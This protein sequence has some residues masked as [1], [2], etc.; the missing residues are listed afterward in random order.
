MEATR[1]MAIVA[2]WRSVPAGSGSAP[3]A[4]IRSTYRS[5]MV[6]ALLPDHANENLDE[7]RLQNDL[8]SSASRPVLLVPNGWRE[9]PNGQHITI[10]WEPC[11]RRRASLPFFCSDRNRHHP[12]IGVRDGSRGH[13]SR[14]SRTRAHAK[15]LRNLLRRATSCARRR[16]NWPTY[17]RRGRK[18][19]QRPHRD[20]GLLVLTLTPHH[21]RCRNR[22]DS[23]L[24]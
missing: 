22:R 5:D 19:W 16:Q 11:L 3:P 24:E 8:I 9:R 20:W 4:L 2:E 18:R 17:N 10:V 1:T 14:G 12:D 7:L 13:L 15:P 6:I 23:A 21:A